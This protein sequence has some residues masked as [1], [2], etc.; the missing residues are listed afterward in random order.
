M[1]LSW[2]FTGVSGF[3]IQ[4]RRLNQLSTKTFE[5]PLSFNEVRPYFLKLQSNPTV[6]QR[7]I[8]KLSTYYK[9]LSVAQLSDRSQLNS[10]LYFSSVFCNKI[11][12]KLIEAAQL[13]S[14][15]IEISVL[16]IFGQKLFRL[17]Q[18][19]VAEKIIDEKFKSFEREEGES[20]KF[21]VYALNGNFRK[22]IEQLPLMAKSEIPQEIYYLLLNLINFKDG[23]EVGEILKATPKYNYEN[24]GKLLQIAVKGK[25]LSKMPMTFEVF[26]RQAEALSSR[27]ELEPSLLI[28]AFNKCDGIDRVE[29]LNLEQIKQLKSIFKAVTEGKLNLLANNLK[30]L[31]KKLPKE[32]SSTLLAELCQ[33]PFGSDE[34]ARSSLLC[35]IIKY[36]PENY[37]YELL[38]TEF[39]QA[40]DD[41]VA[42]IALEAIGLNDENVMNFIEF[43][44]MEKGI[45]I[46]KVSLRDAVDIS[47]ENFNY[48][49]SDEFM[50][51]IHRKGYN[52]SSK[53]YLKRL[54]Q[55][56]QSNSANSYRAFECF[57]LIS[58][59]SLHGELLQEYLRLSQELL[60]MMIKSSNL[61]SCHKIYSIISK[62][63]ILKSLD[64][65]KS[66]NDF[67]LEKFLNGKFEHSFKA[68]L[69]M[70]CIKAIL[71]SIQQQQKKNQQHSSVILSENFCVVAFQ[72]ALSNFDFFT[73]NRLRV[74]MNNCGYSDGG[75]SFSQN[76]LKNW[77][78]KL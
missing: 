36:Y 61:D 52:L 16:R 46:D 28:L 35:W 75:I 42:K 25:L 70:D 37:S 8:S 71:D 27:F 31:E 60:E 13:Y 7:E 32:I 59:D 57:K 6:H 48:E 49:P 68:T 66:F 1:M 54:K 53:F 69:N 15:E 9:N 24:W 29:E 77:L 47:Y 55:I 56:I 45:F 30:L 11:S 50:K 38:M 3:K 64:R 17:N 14:E 22:M 40:V 62:Y 76:I 65:S 63:Q 39:S 73:A 12:L 33:D 74:Y 5:A 20:F 34:I 18:W 21:E 4:I 51:F 10:A 44:L 19:P 72:A 23:S 78:R 58:A 26:L 43:C 67:V 41:N 2:C